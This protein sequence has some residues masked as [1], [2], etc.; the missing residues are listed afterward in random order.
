MGVETKQA[1]RTNGDGSIY[2]DKNGRW[3]ASLDVGIGIDGKRMRVKRTR[4]TKQEAA[5]ALRELQ[6]KKLNKRLVSNESHTVKDLYQQWEKYGMSDNLRDTT[7]QDYLYLSKRYVLPALGHMRLVDVETTTIDKWLFGMQQR[8]LS[9]ITRR[10]ARQN[11]YAI[12]KFGIKQRQILINPVTGSTVPKREKNHVTQVR[13][14]LS[15]PEWMD[16][17]EKFRE[18]PLDTFVH[19][20]ALLGLRRGEIIGLNWSDIDFETNYLFVR[21]SARELTVRR[22]DG[23]SQTTL[24]L[25]DPKTKHSKRKL[26]MNPALVDTL[27]RQQLR[28]KK[29]K[30]AAGSAWNENDAVFTSSIGTRLYPSNVHKQ[31]KK[32]TQSLGLRYVRIHDLRHTVAHLLLDEEIPLESVSRLL[33]HSSLSITMDIYGQNVQSVADRGARGMADL[34][35]KN[36]KG[37]KLKRLHAHM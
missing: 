3:I 2:Q 36:Q 14:P 12:F 7:K 1:R 23:S 5:H 13:L 29:A 9:A 37:F 33:G 8:G 21:H 16:Y 25:N 18:T 10:K 32:L 17:L 11:A 35:E 34:Y 30:L 20:G 15:K 4:K 6:A 26:E 19:I 28:Q 27:R 31:Y 24:V 22:P